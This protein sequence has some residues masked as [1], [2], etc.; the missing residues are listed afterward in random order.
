MARTRDE[1]KF[2]QCRDSLISVGE[3]LFISNSFNSVGLNDILKHAGIPKGSFY[4]YFES[5]EDFALQVVEQ[6]HKASHAALEELL[7]DASLDAYQQLKTF[8]ENNVEHFCDVGYC[9]GCLMANLSQEVADVNERMRCKI[10]MLS[11]EMVDK[12]SEGLQRLQNNELNLGH[13]KPCE[14]AQVVMNSWMG[15][16]M[17]MKLEKSREPLDVFMKFFFSA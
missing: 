17:K 5:K 3:E 11:T 8:F 14:A 2:N 16:V 1:L 4:H 10:S 12:V 13:L 15:A 9:Q 6:Y 7:Q